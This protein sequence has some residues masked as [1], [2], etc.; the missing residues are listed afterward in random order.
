MKNIFIFAF[1]ACIVI[2]LSAETIVNKPIQIYNYPLSCF[3]YSSG[4]YQVDEKLGATTR[5]VRLKTVGVNGGY[6]VKF[7]KTLIILQKPA[8]R[9]SVI[10]VDY[11]MND[12]G[13]TIE[14]KE[15][16]HY[17]FDTEENYGFD[18]INF[19]CTISINGGENAGEISP[20][21]I[22]M[23]IEQCDLQLLLLCSAAQ[24][25]IE[26]CASAEKSDVE[27]IKLDAYTEAVA[28]KVLGYARGDYTNFISVFGPK[29][30]AEIIEPEVS[31]E[32]EI[33]N[34]KKVKDKNE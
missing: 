29:E 32:P 17:V 18:G 1:L 19:G 6:G 30:E 9:Y 7:C 15:K 25:I 27:S 20:G 14:S 26:S 12:D 34:E 8:V 28:S 3:V 11:E 16:I 2:S 24:K 5:T 33:I 22:P 10:I 4:D 21:S 13:T 31:V 23:R